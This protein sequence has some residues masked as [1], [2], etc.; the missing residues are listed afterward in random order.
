MRSSFRPL[1]PYNRPSLGWLY[2]WDETKKIK[3]CSLVSLF[4]P[5][6]T[7]F[8]SK[9]SD[10]TALNKL[11]FMLFCAVIFASASSAVSTTMALFS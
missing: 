5:C 3:K 8:T 2:Y 6:K 10:M 7:D 9:A 1:I 4:I 11:R